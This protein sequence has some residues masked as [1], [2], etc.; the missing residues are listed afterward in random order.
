MEDDLLAYTDRF[1]TTLETTHRKISMAVLSQLHTDLTR[2]QLFLLFMIAKEG[3]PKQTHLAEKMGVK[4]SAITV[5]I[6]RLVQSGHVV[7]KHHETDRRIVLVEVTDTGKAIIKLTEDVQRD[8]IARG[9]SQL[10]PEDR[11]VLV[12]AFEQLNSFY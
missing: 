12:S 3:M 8:I 11:H 9:L 4:P 1:R 6:D 2:P 7:R 5:M 10:T